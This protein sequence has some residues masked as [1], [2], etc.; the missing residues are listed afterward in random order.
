MWAN[1]IVLHHPH[2]ATP[3]SSVLPGISAWDLDI[4]PLLYADL[5]TVPYSVSTNHPIVKDARF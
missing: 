5:P 3:E 1:A 4:L 2:S